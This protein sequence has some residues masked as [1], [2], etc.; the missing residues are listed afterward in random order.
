MKLSELPL[1]L[2]C[3]KDKIFCVAQELDVDVCVSQEQEIIK[4][5]D[6]ESASNQQ[7]GTPCEEQRSVKKQF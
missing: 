7:S 3:P 1:G 5:V 4:L 2:T 6:N